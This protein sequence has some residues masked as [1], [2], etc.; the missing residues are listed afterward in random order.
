MEYCIVTGRSL[1]WLLTS[2]F[3]TLVML[4][5]L[6]NP[7]WLTATPQEVTLGNETILFTPSVGVYTKCY[8]PK[9]GEV[10]PDCSTIAVRGLATDANVFPVAWKISFVFIA[11]GLAIMTL[12]IISGA[13]G[14]Y[15]QSIFKKSI[16]TVSG[17]TQTIAGICFIIGV[18]SYPFAWDSRR[19][20]F[21]CSNTSSAF[22]PGECSLGL[23]LYLAALGT[24]LTFIV[25][26]LSVSADKS[27]SS[28]RVQDQID[29]GHTLICLP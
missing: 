20:R 28:D 3:T 1:F 19:V 8:K 27:T 5:A 15:F 29:E 10:V 17:A 14:C 7:A 16:F 13:I 6:F 9:K 2:L 12:T 23:G 25:A 18:M 21:L 4:A 26:C 24:A 11:L 22:F